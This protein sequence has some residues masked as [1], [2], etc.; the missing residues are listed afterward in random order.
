[1]NKKAELLCSEIF[2]YSLDV[3]IVLTELLVVE[4]KLI[5]KVGRHLLDLIVGEGLGRRD[6]IIMDLRRS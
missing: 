1:M 6:E 4:A 2:R 5:H 3:F